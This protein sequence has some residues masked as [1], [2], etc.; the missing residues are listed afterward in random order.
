MQKVSLEPCIRLVLFVILALGLSDK[1]Y[2]LIILFFPYIS[3]QMNCFA[4]MLFLVGPWVSW[5]DLLIIGGFAFIYY[6]FTL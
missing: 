2:H 3:F 6:K 4:L 5:W 1:K